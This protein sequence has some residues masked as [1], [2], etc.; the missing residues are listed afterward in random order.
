MASAYNKK[1]VA[2]WALFD[3]ATSSF[4]TTMVTFVFP[5]Y[6]GKV[7]APPGQGAVYWGRTMFGSMLLVA[8][9]TPL[10]GAMA[11]VLRNK[12]LY[13]GI[14][15]AVSI[16]CTAALYFM[17]P[18]MVL[19]AAAMFLL[20]NAGYEGGT[21]FFDAFLPEISKPST[22]G[23][24]SG[25]G[26]AAGYTGSLLVLLGCLPLLDWPKSTFLYSALWFAVFA[27]P[28]FLFVPE[29]RKKR[30]G[31]M[32]QV[33]RQAFGQLMATFRNIRQYKDV[34]RFLLAFFIYN[35]GIRTVVVFSG[36]YSTDTLHFTLEEVA[37]F[38][39]MIQVIAVIGSLY[40]GRFADRRGPKLAITITL[41]I[42]IGVVILA[43]FATTK[44][45]FYL[46]GALA[47]VA[48]GSSQSCSRSMM[49]LLTP[50]DR[51]AEF[52]GFYDG[53]CGKSSA[54][55]GALLFGELTRFFG[56]NE[57]PAV[58]LIGSFFIVGLIL[59]SRVKEQRAAPE[60]IDLELA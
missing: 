6:F 8:I 3:F 29:R 54:V 36:I 7:I 47:G 38:F 17:Q 11:D 2:S 14:F 50:P 5:I 35:D 20:A 51:A 30:D 40:F 41:F 24:I 4:S 46:V 16:V 21:V 48:L 49:A 53:F 34:A 1:T 55:L 22:F 19:L 59:L 32:T 45:S 37:I 56:G 57:R 43:Y 28:L 13:L 58:L 25:F 52:F 26:Y 42:W 18:G 23:R 44:A 31:S 15:A 27:I 9:I 33:T 39:I 12:K 60:A 10:L